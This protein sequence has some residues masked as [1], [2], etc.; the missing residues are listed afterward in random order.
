MREN[1]YD[2]GNGRHLSVLTG[3]VE[4]KNY[5]AVASSLVRNGYTITATEFV[6]FGVM[7][8]TAEKIV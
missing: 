2:L 1:R 5:K 3:K 8:M 4:T 6:D 7:R